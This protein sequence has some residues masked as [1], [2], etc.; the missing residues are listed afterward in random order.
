MQKMTGCVVQRD[1]SG[2]VIGDNK[3]CVTSHEVCVNGI[4]LYFEDDEFV[5]KTR[6]KL[7]R[8]N[9]LNRKQMLL[10]NIAA[11]V[12]APNWSG[13]EDDTTANWSLHLLHQHVPHVRDNMFESPTLSVVWTKERIMYRVKARG[14]WVGGFIAHHGIMYIINAPA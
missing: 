2:F 12:N 14:V 7:V 8:F 11:F 5:V 4:L 3:V 13:E 1:G 9:Y 10:T 6:D